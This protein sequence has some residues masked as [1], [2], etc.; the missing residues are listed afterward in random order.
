M[1]P[2]LSFSHTMTMKVMSAVATANVDYSDSC[3]RKVM[4]RCNL[5]CPKPFGRHEFL[6]HVAISSSSSLRL[7][8][9]GRIQ[10]EI[11]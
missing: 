5:V 4:A 11:L 6:M 10:Q 1:E 8:I 3:T 7:K 9:F 2:R